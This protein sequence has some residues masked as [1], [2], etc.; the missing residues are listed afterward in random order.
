METNSNTMTG[1]GSMGGM[2]NTTGTADMGN[3]VA[4][5]V[6]QATSSAHR[7]IDRASEAARPTVDKVA[8]GAHQLV[9]KIAGAAS[10]AAD[11][12]DTKTGELRDVHERLTESCREYVRENPLASI[13]IAVA[14][15]FLLSRLMSSR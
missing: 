6:D 3:G 8:A 12:L 1:T 15:G 11:K 14:A 9:D 7:A 4:R 13:G 10:T 5:T 2:G